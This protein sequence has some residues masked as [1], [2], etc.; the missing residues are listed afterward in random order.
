MSLSSSREEVDS[1]RPGKFVESFRELPGPQ[2]RETIR[3]WDRRAIEDLG[4]PGAVLM[5]N[6]GVAAARVIAGL[7]T[8]EPG[9]YRSPYLIL[10]G[11]GNNGG[12][13]LV[14]AR[15]LFDWGFEVGIQIP[16]GVSYLEGSDAR[17]HF[18]VMRRLK[19]PISPP[20]MAE[21]PRAGTIIDALFG[22]GL[23]RPLEAPWIDWVRAVNASA[24]PTI[25]LDIPSGL[26]AN[27]G[28]ILGEAVRA[29]HTITFA[30]SK[31]GFALAM[32]PE[33][34]GQVHVRDIGLPGRAMG[35]GPPA[36]ISGP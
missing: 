6:A 15:Y 3:E 30:A 13:G 4:I 27:S 34:C 21:I 1:H 20:S 9:T 35:L 28:V 18:E 31:V 11:P 33:R 10:C 2:R 29:R 23:S 19:I 22:T 8:S 32:G 25:S 14:V 26:D 7:A 36:R 16:G 24:R 17:T 5:E 12:D